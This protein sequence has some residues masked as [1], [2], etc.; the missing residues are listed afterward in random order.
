MRI[1]VFCSANSE[2]EADFFSAA[3]KLAQGLAKRKWELVYGGARVGLMGSIADAMLKAGGLVRG[4]ITED[5]AVERE[6]P[7][8]GIQELVV[9]QDLFDRKRWMMDHADAFVIL[10]GGYGTLDEAL[11][12]ITWKTLKCHDKPILFVNVAGFWQSQLNVFGEFKK[13][14]MIRAHGPA[15]ETGENQKAELYDVCNT[16]DEVWT[17]LDDIS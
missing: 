10:P 2:I 12:V 16:L 4:A 11:E 6:M 17:V 5:L 1:A 7:H 13:R 14:G 3:E 15:S 8:K 9:V